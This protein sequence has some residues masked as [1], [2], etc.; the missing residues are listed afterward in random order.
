MGF[1][2]GRFL[3]GIDQRRKEERIQNEQNLR[4][5][6]ELPPVITKLHERLRK[7]IFNNPE[8]AVQ[9][10]EFFSVYGEET[11]K[12][13]M[14][15]VLALRKKFEAKETPERKK[16]KI[17]SETFEGIVLLNAQ[18][19]NWFG[20]AKFFKTS[21]YDDLKNKT[22]MFG[23]W[24]DPQEG[25][26]VLALAIDLTFSRGAGE[27]KLNVIKSAIDSGQMGSIRYFKDA[28]GD[29]KGM[30]FNVPR[31][32]LGVGSRELAE[33]A[34]L[35]LLN[36]RDQLK[37]HPARAM[38]IQE[39]HTE[40]IGMEHYASRTGKTEVARAYQQALAAVGP[41]YNEISGRATVS[42]DPVLQTIEARMKAFA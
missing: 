30:R 8:Y 41:L 7:E 24:Y 33:L 32:V 17:L 29:Y 2:E 18:Q 3:A 16:A 1:N 13:E 9:A 35:T 19:N 10:P 21:S 37:N 26:R 22:D 23:E 39:M 36:K 38:L 42:D 6:L 15:E 27:N 11:V 28:R 4:H 40:L 31:I 20:D 5:G 14:R 25:S 12:Q 34:S